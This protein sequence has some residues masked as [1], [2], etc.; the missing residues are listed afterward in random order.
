MED[1]SSTQAT[2]PLL[3]ENILS[4]GLVTCVFYAQLF[5]IW[6]SM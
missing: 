6:Y 2:L 4:V 1:T 3:L 5:N